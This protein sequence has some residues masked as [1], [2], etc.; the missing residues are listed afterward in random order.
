VS[1]SRNIEEL[2]Q[3][4]RENQTK[5][6]SIISDADRNSKFASLSGKMPIPT[7]G[8][9]SAK[10]NQKTNLGITS[11]GITIE[12]K[13]NAQVIAPYDAAIIFANVFRSGKTTIILYH[14][15]NYYTVLTGVDKSFVKEGSNVL[16]GE[17]IAEMGGKNTSLQVELRYKDKTIDP[18]SYFT[19]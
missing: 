15:N 7:T 4:A 14:G 17:P 2:I 11:K 19:N 18:L 1:E 13:N 9:I 12:T 6:S 5:Y 10:F 8:K 16:A 3:K